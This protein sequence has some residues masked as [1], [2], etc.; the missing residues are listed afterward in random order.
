MTAVPHP[1]GPGFNYRF[2]GEV[3]AA[4]GGHDVVGPLYATTTELGARFPAGI[5]TFWRPSIIDRLRSPVLLFDAAGLGLLAVAGTQKALAFGLTPVMPDLD[6][7]TGFR[8]REWQK[9]WRLIKL[10][11][12]CGAKL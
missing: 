10:G 2:M 3:G 11:Q 4:R 6:S 8:R 1:A 7:R 12:K 9:C 5:V